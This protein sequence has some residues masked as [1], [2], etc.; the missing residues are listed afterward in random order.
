[1]L[2]LVNDLYK[3]NLLVYLNFLTKSEVPALPDDK[4]IP[5]E[6]VELC[7]KT[8]GFSVKGASVCH[9]QKLMIGHI[10]SYLNSNSESFMRT[11]RLTSAQKKL[12]FS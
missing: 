8:Y 3:S 7:E 11:H 1:M 9:E 2:D 10:Q 6:L 5:P 4:A 12:L